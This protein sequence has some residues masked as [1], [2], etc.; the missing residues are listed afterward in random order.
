LPLIVRLTELNDR[1]TFEWYTNLRLTG[2][3]A[4]TD[5]FASKRSCTTKDEEGSG[6]KK[7]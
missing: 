1:I 3:Y 5:R 2:A 7:R 4:E 6:K